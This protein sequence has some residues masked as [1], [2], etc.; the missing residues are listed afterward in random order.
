M[1]EFNDDSGDGKVS[2]FNE[3]ALRMRR[4][5]EGQRRITF[6]MMNLL[7]FDEFLKKYE[8]EKAIAEIIGLLNQSFG[9]MTD[10]E[11]KKY[12]AFR[13]RSTLLCEMFPVFINKVSNGLSKEN[14]RELNKINYINIRQIIFN[15]QDFLQEV[16]E[17]AGWSSPNQDKEEGYD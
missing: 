16:M 11:K 9:K 6:S 1:G 12:F 17:R 3:A 4:F 8:Y 7:S 10:D 15:M 13:M 14:Y 5:D 2:S